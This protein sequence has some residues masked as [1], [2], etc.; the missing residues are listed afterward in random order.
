MAKYS[1]H[2]FNTIKTFKLRPGKPT[3]WHQFKEAN[4]YPN[5]PKE[6]ESPLFIDPTVPAEVEEDETWSTLAENSFQI[7]SQQKSRATFKS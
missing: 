1:Q 7:F 6:E 2:F 5:K 4:W 3:E